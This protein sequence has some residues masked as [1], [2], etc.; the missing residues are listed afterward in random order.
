MAHIGRPLDPWQASMVVDSFGVRAD[1]RWAARE[2]VVLVP[3]Q[4][5]KGGFTEAE[6]LGGLFLLKERM[7]LHSAHLFPT[8]VQA[9]QRLVDII[10][11]SDWL[12]KRVK[13]ISRSKGAE[14]ITLTRAAGGGELKFVARTVGGA[15]GFT[16]SR[17]IFDE[18]YA[19]TAAQ[20]AAQTPTL[21][22]IPN[23]QI[24]YTS[25]PP[26]EDTGPMPEDAMLPSVRRRGM[27]G[28]PRMAYYEWSPEPGA[29]ESDP[30]TWYDCNPALGI[31]IEEEF[32]VD[33]LRAFTAAGRSGK[34]ATE[35]LGVWPPSPDEQWQVIGEAEWTDA[36]DPGSKAEGG[37]AIGISLTADRSRAT[38]AIFGRRA[39]GLRHGQLIE[40]GAGSGWVVESVK[41]AKASRQICAVVIGAADPARSLLPDFEAAGIEVLT[42]GT[43]DVAAECGAFYDGIAGKDVTTRDIRHPEQGPLTASIAS[44]AKKKAGDSWVWER[45][46]VG[47]DVSPLFAITN[48]SYGYRVSPPDDYNIADSVM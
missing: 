11:G 14:G 16:G 3:R 35:H 45:L 2:V 13:A 31:R 22:T 37:V 39:D 9:M 38:I 17:L 27:Q 44:A 47:M 46:G 36:G 29:D 33:Q 8:A 20:F 7:I 10:E 42:P 19:L 48:A 26:D 21:A 4:N 28:D 1:G 24:T 5:G 30:D 12:T 15:R 40:Q 32:L 18:A 41:K 43:A 34:F 25:T 6:E 23:H